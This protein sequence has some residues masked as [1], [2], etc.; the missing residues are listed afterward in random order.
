[1]TAVRRGRRKNKQTKKPHDDRWDRVGC[2]GYML[3]RDIFVRLIVREQCQSLA[4]CTLLVTTHQPPLWTWSTTGEIALWETSETW[5]ERVAERTPLNSKGGGGLC[6]DLAT[7]QNRRTKV[8]IHP[9]PKSYGHSFIIHP[10]LKY[11]ETSSVWNIL[12]QE[13]VWV[14]SIRPDIWPVSLNPHKEIKH[15]LLCWLT[16]WSVL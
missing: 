11:G 14:S 7:G 16:S 10:G 12:Q 2:L 6:L 8:F 15:T 9:H 13:Y 1:M 3:R 5:K 4:R